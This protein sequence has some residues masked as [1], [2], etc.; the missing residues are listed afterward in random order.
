M[1]RL[2]PD[3]N[4]KNRSEAGGTLNALC[5]AGQACKKQIVFTSGLGRLPRHFATPFGH[6]STA[7]PTLIVTFQYSPKLP[8][9]ARRFSNPC[10]RETCLF[11][12][13]RHISQYSAFAKTVSPKRPTLKTLSEANKRNSQPF[14][15]IHY[16]LA[17]YARAT[18]CYS[19]CHRRW[20][21]SPPQL[22]IRGG[23]V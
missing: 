19:T 21:R 5:G 23:G 8:H 11:L 7:T 3:T 9:C 2:Q 1:R 20:E 13:A 18:V 17:L 22:K 10:S 12:T 16:Q 6:C 4:R 15:T 14:A